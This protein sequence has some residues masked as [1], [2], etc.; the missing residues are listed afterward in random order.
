M[1]KLELGVNRHTLPI[2]RLVERLR[3]ITGREVV[4]VDPTGMGVRSPILLVARDPCAVGAFASIRHAPCLT[5]ARERAVCAALGL[6]PAVVCRWHAIPHHVGRRDPTATEWEEGRQALRKLLALFPPDVVVVGSGVEARV[7]LRRAGHRD[8]VVIPSTAAKGCPTA[9]RRRARE[10]TSERR[11]REGLRTAMRRA[12]M[13]PVETA[14][15]GGLEREEVARRRGTAT[16]E[17]CRA[18]WRSAS[19][20]AP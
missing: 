3:S 18:G 1:G 10:Q 2:E 12:G 4:H 17:R 16:A 15:A 9:A 19:R 7:Q 14:A 8:V 6:D 13:I 11:I 20:H 5:A